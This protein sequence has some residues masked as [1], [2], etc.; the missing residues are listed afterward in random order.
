MVIM[1]FFKT[2]DA[3]LSFT[4]ATVNHT[5]NLTE[6]IYFIKGNVPMIEKPVVDLHYTSVNWFLCDRIICLRLICRIRIL[7]NTGKYMRRSLK[8]V[9]FFA[10]GYSTFYM[11]LVSTLVMEEKEGP[12]QLLNT[13]F[14]S[15]WRF[16]GDCFAR[17]CFLR[18]I[19]AWR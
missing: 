19:F 4:H 15:S 7:A 8:I 14:N 11:Q 17:C 18:T 13:L 9:T 2:T 16:T 3:F 10:G 1:H 12:G 6:T 5:G